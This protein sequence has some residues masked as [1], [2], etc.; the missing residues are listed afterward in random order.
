MVLILEFWSPNAGES[1]LPDIPANK[2]R[3]HGSLG[4]VIQQRLRTHIWKL[5][6][7]EPVSLHLPPL[8]MVF[9]TAIGARH[10]IPGMCIFLLQMFTDE[11]LY[12]SLRYLEALDLFIPWKELCVASAL[13]SI[14]LQQDGT[15][16]RICL[17]GPKGI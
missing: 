6:S 1:Q 14:C 12:Q 7:W 3:T 5:L 10:L 4:D 15:E 16:G 11:Q 17:F 2:V 13:A 8:S 9:E